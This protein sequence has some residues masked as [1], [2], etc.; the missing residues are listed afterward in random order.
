MPVAVKT[1]ENVKIPKNVQVQF[2]EGCT[3]TVSG[4][5]GKFK[6]T[7]YH[8]AV[9]VERAGDEIVFSCDFPRKKQKAMVRT[10]ASHLNNMCVGVTDG[11]TY[12][13]KVVYSH[14]PIKTMLKGKQ[15]IIE[16]FLG[17]K[18]PRVANIVGDTKVLVKGND[19]TLIGSN[20]EDVGQSAAN[21]ER[22][23]KIKNRDPRVFQD[24]IYIVSR[25]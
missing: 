15:L 23:T 17:E 3:F 11:F 8:P 24:G 20:V 9:K 7:L 25:K 2:D 22:T 4:P 13:M 21:I 1:I 5:N 6:R 19:I 12:Q 10:L 18:K 14:F 16:N